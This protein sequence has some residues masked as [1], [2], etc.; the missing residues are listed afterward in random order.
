[1]QHPVTAGDAAV[2]TVNEAVHYSAALKQLSAA[3][4]RF[5]AAAATSP[6]PREKQVSAFC[7]QLVTTKNSSKKY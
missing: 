4:A 6:L 2:A 1:M 5:S 3:A 7:N